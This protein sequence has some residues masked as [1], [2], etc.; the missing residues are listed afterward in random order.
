[1]VK[2]RISKIPP[3]LPLTK[4]VPRFAGFGK[5]GEGRFSDGYGNSVLR[6]LLSD[7]E[8]PYESSGIKE[9]RNARCN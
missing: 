9:V 2:T 7:K 6:T 3:I 5:E 8:N 4:G 1:V